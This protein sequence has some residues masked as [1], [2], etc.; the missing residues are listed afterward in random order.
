MTYY[1]VRFTCYQYNSGRG[2]NGIK[3]VQKRFEDKPAAE[4]FAAIIKE[5][6]VKKSREFGSQYVWDGYVERFDGIYE[7]T[8]RRL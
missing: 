8:E 2:D 7:V 6:T 4:A 3:S 1:H 5:Q